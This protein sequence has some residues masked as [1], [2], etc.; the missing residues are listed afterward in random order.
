MQQILPASCRSFKDVFNVAAQLANSS[1][2]IINLHE[3]QDYYHQLDDED[4]HTDKNSE[5]A[6]P[7][8]RILVSSPGDGPIDYPDKVD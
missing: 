6:K 3:R 1:L 2:A 8:L 4:K 7:S 5:V